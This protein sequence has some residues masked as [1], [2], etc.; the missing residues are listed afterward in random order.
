MPDEQDYYRVLGVPRSA[1]PEQIK[2]AYRSLALKYHPDRNP[3][4]AEA[5]AQFKKGAEAYE[6]LSDPQKRRRYDQFGKAGL[7]GTGVHDWAHANMGD[8]FSWVSSIFE[9]FGGF[10][11]QRSRA[12]PRA[13]ASLRCTINVTLEEVAKGVTKTVRVTHREHCEA[14]GGSGSVSGRRETCPTCRGGGRVQQGGGFFRIVRDCPHCSGT[15]TTIADPCPTCG[16]NRF[17]NHKRTIE[18][19]VPPGVE[20]GLRIRYAGQ[21]DAGEPGAP[22]GDLYAAIHEEPHP[23]FERHGMDLLCQ[24]PISFTQAALGAE[25]E[26]PTLDGRETITVTRGTQSGDLARLKGKGLPDVHEYGRG[27]IL[28]QTIVEVPKRLTRRQKELLREFAETEKNGVL[29]IRESFLEKLAGYFRPAEKQRKNDG[30]EAD[31]PA[32]GDAS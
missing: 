20:D 30:A 25:V 4:D 12:G 24:V 5:E 29:P 15:G 31:G 28:A 7:R 32:N 13:G 19:Q 6:V 17:V 10:G 23:F 27:D 8:V 11:A 14:C 16:G 1:S 26:V 2:R 22:R 9:E 3:D 21:G 18:V